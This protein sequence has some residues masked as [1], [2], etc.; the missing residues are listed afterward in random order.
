MDEGEFTQI[1]EHYTN[2]TD[3]DLQSAY[4]AGAESYKSSGVWQLIATEYDRRVALLVEEDAVAGSD[5]S[6]PTRLCER[7]GTPWFFVAQSI[8]TPSRDPSVG[9]PVN[10]FHFTIAVSVLASLFVLVQGIR[11]GIASLMIFG[12]LLGIAVV[13]F[14]LAVDR[15]KPWGWYY[16]TAYY[17]VNLA[18]SIWG[19]LT[20]V[21]APHPSWQILAFATHGLLVGLYVA[22]RRPQFGL[23]G[24]EPVR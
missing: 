7:G 15:S 17:A 4:D 3:E 13:F 22:R 12:A 6:R 24:W 19:T 14:L 8:G 20:S 23:P 9:L 21:Y 5:T 1:K 16:I 10:F 18:L 11:W 2:L